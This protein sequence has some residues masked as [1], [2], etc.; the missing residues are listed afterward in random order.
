MCSLYRTVLSPL[1]AGCAVWRVGST[2]G[3]GCVVC[4]PHVVCAAVH[5]PQCCQVQ[6]EAVKFKRCHRSPWPQC[7]RVQTSKHNEHVQ[8]N[9]C[10]TQLFN[11]INSNSIDQGHSRSMNATLVANKLRE[12][13]RVLHSSVNSALGPVQRSQ[14]AG[15]V[16]SSRRSLLSSSSTP[17]FKR[18]G[19]RLYATSADTAAGADQTKA[20]EPALYVVVGDLEPQ[21][22]PQQ[23]QPARNAQCWC[24]RM[25]LP[26]PVQAVWTA[27]QKRQLNYTR[28]FLY[29]LCT[30]HTHRQP[31]GHVLPG[32]PCAEASRAHP[33]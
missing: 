13:F 5:Q 32:H 4:V 29:T 21:E 19:C 26:C 18:H 31:R 8:N 25:P 10:N 30:G 6:T 23:Q 11:L 20:L 3:F 33:G 24:A 27:L 17:S 16:Y 22:L 7:R 2:A 15:W 28:H 9:E 12:S 14:H 1:S